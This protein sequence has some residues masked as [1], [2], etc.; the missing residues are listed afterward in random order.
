VTKRDASSK[1]PTPAEEPMGET[2]WELTRVVNK[3]RGSDH[4]VVL[5]ITSYIAEALRRLIEQR[6]LDNSGT[7]Q[8]FG[9]GRTPPMESFAARASLAFALGLITS[10]EFRW[11]T[12]TRKIRNWFAHELN[13]SFSDDKIAFKCFSFDPSAK[14]PPVDQRYSTHRKRGEACREEFV[15]HALTLSLSLGARVKLG[16]IERIQPLFSQKGEGEVGSPEERPTKKNTRRTADGRGGTTVSR[17]L[18]S[19]L[20]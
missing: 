20:K 16:R 13:P 14:I 17:P 9:D 2:D 12:L 8:L 5:L 11:I 15:K 1:T 10:Q 18:R 4:E 19:N 3:L 7:R 6:V